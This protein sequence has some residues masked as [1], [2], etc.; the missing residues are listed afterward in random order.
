[1][2]T[3]CIDVQNVHG[4][5]LQVNQYANSDDGSN[6]SNEQKEKVKAQAK[7][8]TK[9]SSGHMTHSHTS[10]E[11]EKHIVHQEKDLDDERIQN[12]DNG[13][14]CVVESVTATNILPQNVH[15]VK[16]KDEGQHP[17]HHQDQHFTQDLP[18]LQIQ[19]PHPWAIHR[20]T[21]CNNELQVR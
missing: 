6:S 13:T 9:V 4:A 3:C 11:K 10:K 5:D 8:V 7:V 20:R 15:K 2:C 1:M 17:P 18:H 16:D 21:I 14:S 12:I 19:P